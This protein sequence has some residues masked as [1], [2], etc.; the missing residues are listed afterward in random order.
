M[1]RK[2]KTPASPDT[3]RAELA[4]LAGKIAAA[5]IAYH[6]KDAPEVTDAEYD[7]WRRRHAEMP[8]ARLAQHAAAAGAEH[9][10]LLD[11]EGLDHILER[12]EIGRAHV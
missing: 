10:A 5:D 2:P 1:S 12:V 11:Q 9:Q 3:A 4:A 7:G 6:G 8:P